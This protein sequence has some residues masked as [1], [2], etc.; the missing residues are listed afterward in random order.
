[1]NAAFMSL[2]QHERGIHAVHLGTDGA[3]VARVPLSGVLPRNWCPAA[4]LV[5]GRAIGAPL[6][7]GL[8]APGAVQSRQASIYCENAVITLL[9]SDVS[10]R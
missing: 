7:V 2:E 1:M 4:Q 10:V 6:R 8:P 3:G 9:T 5:P